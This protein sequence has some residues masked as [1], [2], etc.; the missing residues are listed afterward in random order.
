MLSEDF[1]G[2]GFLK[3][4]RS[5]GG[6]DPSTDGM[7]YTVDGAMLDHSAKRFIEGKP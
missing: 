4:E 7:F 3:K 6:I 1:V 5:K 2:R